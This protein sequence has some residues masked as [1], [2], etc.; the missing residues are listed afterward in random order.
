MVAVIYYDLDEVTAAD[1]AAALAHCASPCVEVVS[2][3]TTWNIA[4]SASASAS[5][6]GSSVRLPGARE[7]AT[8]DRTY[9]WLR[10]L[11]PALK[12]EAS[13]EW[14]PHGEELFGAMLVTV[15]S[16]LRKDLNRW[17][18]FEAI[19]SRWSPDLLVWV[20]RSTTSWDAQA[21]QSWVSALSAR[22]VNVLS[23]NTRATSRRGEL[24]ELAYATLQP[25]R[26]RLRARRQAR[27]SPGGAL[28]TS[29]DSNRPLVLF[30]DNYPNN[31]SVTAELSKALTQK[32]EVSV[33][34]LAGRQEV[35]DALRA[36]HLACRQLGEFGGAL[37][38]SL[39]SRRTRRKRLESALARVPHSALGLSDG[40]LT[41]RRYLEEVAANSIL[42]AGRSAIP[43]ATQFS[44]A[45]AALRPDVV[46]ST[47]HSGMQ[48][49]LCVQAAHQVGAHAV[50]VQHGVLSPHRLNADFAHETQL[51]WGDKERDNQERWGES[52]AG[53]RVIGSLKH[54][55]LG[56]DEDPA[57]ELGAPLRVLFFA[58]R[59]GG[60]VVGSAAARIA[61]EVVASAVRA[62]DDAVL[63]V[64]TH[65]NDRTGLAQQVL[66][67]APGV[68]VVT[69]GS[70]AA[71]VRK[72][73]V[74]IVMSSTTGYDACLLERPLIV[75]G[76]SAVDEGGY[77]GYGAALPAEDEDELVASLLAI[78]NDFDVRE[79]LAEGR[80]RFTSHAVVAAGSEPLRRATA[81]ITAIAADRQRAQR[82]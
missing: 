49:R 61:L 33:A 2:T 46:V 4:A 13:P 40:E 29:V 9:Q 39:P 38:L 22:G 42:N 51:F 28:P 55:A 3:G 41:F 47:N 81:L 58:S 56:A 57:R 5:A 68:S 6:S 79:Q 59:T 34:W 26:E 74:V 71:L 66:G 16:E 73:D 69:D 24:R 8:F 65:P 20:S 15:G 12:T 35:S 63:T 62:S 82:S 53:A 70:A 36:R 48:D 52:T 23:L 7:T 18:C 1:R 80:K 17:W 50:F 27:S 19:D 75:F 14:A 72:H 78:R 76:G 25:I 30:Y 43:M 60:M 21:T 77:L 67:G 37:S 10:A 45:M 11:V 31:L 54:E 64:K 32:G 44:M